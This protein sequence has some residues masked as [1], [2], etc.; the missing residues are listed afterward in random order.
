MS[1]QNAVC[2]VLARHKT[3]G[4]SG[5]VV[6]E[7]NSRKKVESECFVVSTVQRPVED[8][9]D[10]IIHDIVEEIVP[11]ETEEEVLDFL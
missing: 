5:F 3:K 11:R 4:L 10:N 6:L 8:L 2:D 1:V 7:R 9:L